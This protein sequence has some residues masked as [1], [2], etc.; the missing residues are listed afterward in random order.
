MSESESV[1]PSRDDRPVSFYWA[2]G[3]VEEGRAVVERMLEQGTDAAPMGRLTVVFVDAA[4]DPPVGAIAV[5]PMTDKMRQASGGRIAYVLGRSMDDP[6]S[7]S[8]AP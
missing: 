1:R 7:S 5:V 4:E 3:F 6:H 2:E 8:C